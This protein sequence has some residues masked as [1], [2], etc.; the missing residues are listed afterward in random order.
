M[1][2]VPARDPGN[3]HELKFATRFRGRL[4]TP[5]VPFRFV[6]LTKYRFHLSKN[7]L[8]YGLSVLGDYPYRLM[9]KTFRKCSKI[10]CLI[11]K[12][13]LKPRSNGAPNI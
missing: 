8:D 7:M 12:K 11:R 4:G 5:P 9:T 13:L 3:S 10:Y 1:D 2:F 6:P